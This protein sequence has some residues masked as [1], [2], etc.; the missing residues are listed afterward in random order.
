[1][2]IPL[3]ADLPPPLWPRVPSVLLLELG[4]DRIYVDHGLTV[5]KRERC[6]ASSSTRAS[7][8][9]RAATARA[10]RFPA[11]LEHTAQMLGATLL[12]QPA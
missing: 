1:M 6:T 4:A 7:T 2:R 11:V 3:R 10:G 9:I 12:A 8:P 5:A